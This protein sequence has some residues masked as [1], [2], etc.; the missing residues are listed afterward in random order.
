VVL[1]CEWKALPDAVRLLV[2]DLGE[3][4]PKPG[5][6]PAPAFAPASRIQPCNTSGDAQRYER[7]GVSAD[8]GDVHAAIKDMDKG[9]FPKAFCKVVP[10]NITNDP[11]QALVM[12]ADGAGTKAS[13]AYMYWRKTGDLSVWKGIAQDAL[14]M[15]LD[16]LLCV[17]VTDN[18]LLSST[19]GRNKNLIPGDVIASI[20]S[21]TEELSRWLGEHGVNVSLTGGETADVGDLVR[22]VIVDSTVTARIP[23][24]EIVDNA[25][26]CA[27]DI[28][29]GLSSSG[30]ATYEDEYNSGIGSNGLTA[31]RHDTFENGLATE[32][33]ESFDPAMPSD[34]VYSGG[35]KLE[36]LVNA[37]EGGTIPAGKL[38][39]SPTRTYAP[40]VKRIFDSGLRDSIHGMVHCSGGAQTKVLHFVNDVHVVKDNL[41]ATP[42]VF[43][44]I[45][46][47]SQ[48]SWEEMYKVFNMGHRME[49]YTDMETAGKIIEVS[50]SFGIEA[51]VVGRVDAPLAPGEKR[52]TIKSEHGEF[53]YKA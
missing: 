42:P 34:L 9:L 47:H 49:F 48:T 27:G 3:Q 30:R 44:L 45:Q 26:I 14:V 17:G 38:L 12:H 16:D 41:F 33:P 53:V 32:F 39:L 24:A 1:D 21:G 43:Q 6:R 4:T 29:V 7:R 18:I 2:S 10:D 19:I 37:G 52:V 20:I 36:E 46:Q 22:T 51:Q 15:N 13:L 5:S 40:V 11:S 8:K 31:A 25:R 23:R 35:L 50:K 28:I